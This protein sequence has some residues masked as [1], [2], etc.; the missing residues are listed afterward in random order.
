MVEWPKAL[1]SNLECFRV[2]CG[3][4]VHNW[5]TLGKLLILPHSSALICQTTFL[6]QLLQSAYTNSSEAFRYSNYTSVLACGEE[7]EKRNVSIVTTYFH[8]KCCV[9]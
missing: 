6:G 2:N 7:G 8:F 1:L 4:Y 5:V 9:A 3:S